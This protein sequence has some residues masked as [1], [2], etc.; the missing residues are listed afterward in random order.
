MSWLFSQALVE[1]YSA[2]HCSD[3]ELSAQL[4]VMPSPHKFWR[5]D[6]TIEHS[7]LSR[8][9]LT[10]RLLTESR[11][12]ELLMSYRAAFLAKTSAV[13][14]ESKV[15]RASAVD[16]GWKWPESFAKWDHVTSSWRTRQNC[17]IEGSETFSETWPEWG[18]MLD[19]E[20]L[21][22]PN[23]VRP[24]A[25]RASG[26]L[27]TLTASDAKGARNGTAKGRTPADG[28]TVTDWLWLN[29]GPGMLH[30][31]SAKWMML[32]PIGWTALEPLEMDRFQ[33]WLQQHSPF[34]HDDV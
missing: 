3:G 17:F 33:T 30:P 16:F 7:D 2:A 31:E 8:F 12:E 34:S 5:N 21:A 9:G 14:E 25:G 29:V 20:S 11:G 6:K 32:W 22:E 4:N 10:S 19:G 13:P 24:K 28:L 18:S 15:S 26:L 1:E 23:V 27:P